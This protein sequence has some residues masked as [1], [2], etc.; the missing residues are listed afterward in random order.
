MENNNNGKIITGS[1]VIGAL[2]GAT[3]GVLFAPHKGKKTRNKMVN[4]FKKSANE[5]RTEFSEDG[6]YIKNKALDFGNQLK[7]KVNDEVT[8]MKDIAKDLLHSGSDNE[9]N[10]NK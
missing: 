7:N 6:K 10:K 3:L 8:S 4:G 1:L 5:L 2:I 9:N